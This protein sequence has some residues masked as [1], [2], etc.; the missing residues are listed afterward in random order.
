[1]AKFNEIS[2][3]DMSMPVKEPENV[4]VALEGKMTSEL[5]KTRNINN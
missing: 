4:I 3:D 2:E 1:M 5:L